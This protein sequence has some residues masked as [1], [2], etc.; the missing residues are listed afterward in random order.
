M[1]RIRTRLKQPGYELG[2][3]LCGSYRVAES[4]NARV[5]YRIGVRLVIEQLPDHPEAPDGTC[6]HEEGLAICIG[7]VQRFVLFEMSADR[8]S[9]LGLCRLEQGSMVDHAGHGVGAAE[10]PVGAQAVSQGWGAGFGGGGGGTR[11][12][13]GLFAHKNAEQRR[14]HGRRPKSHINGP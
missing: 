5:I 10:Q 1:M 13:R 11:P 6:H 4:V 14:P 3:V 2:V 12:P 7:K 8:L 9:I